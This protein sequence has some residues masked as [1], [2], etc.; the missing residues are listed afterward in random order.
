MVMETVSIPIFSY[1]KGS[2]VSVATKD[3]E[4]TF[5]VSDS[6]AEQLVQLNV[7]KGD[8]IWI[9]AQTGEVSKIG[10]AKDF[11]GAKTYDIDT[12]RRVDIPTG[13]IKKEKE[14]TITVTLHDLDLNVAARNISITAPFS[15]FT[16]REINSDIRQNVDKLVKDMISRGEGEL[17]PGVLFIDDAHMLDIEAFS[18]LTEAL[19]SDLAPILILATNRGITKIRGTNIESSHRM[20]L[21]LLDRLFPL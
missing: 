21:D 14:T 18:F 12:V 9:D 10:K 2:T 7:R 16:E 8:V 20:V 11:E 3:E 6:I 1:A 19:E 4:K 5:N 17:V 13:P 15:F